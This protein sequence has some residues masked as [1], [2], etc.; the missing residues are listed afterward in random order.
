MQWKWIITIIYKTFKKTFQM[1]REKINLFQ[2]HD[3]K[4]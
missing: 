2:N 1:I 3:K 4:L